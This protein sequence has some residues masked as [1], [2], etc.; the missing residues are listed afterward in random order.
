MH[1]FINVCV[2]IFLVTEQVKNHLSSYIHVCNY[3]RS[4]P[5]RKLCEVL[6]I[7]DELVLNDEIPNKVAVLVRDLISY[8]NRVH[9]TECNGTCKKQTQKRGFCTL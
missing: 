5:R 4:L 6:Y 9:I 3:L 2:C 1:V 8:R 7:T